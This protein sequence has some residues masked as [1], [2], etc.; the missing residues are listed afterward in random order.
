MLAEFDVSTSFYERQ[1][2]IVQDMKILHYSPIQQTSIEYYK[3]WY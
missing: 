1:T 3:R 2:S